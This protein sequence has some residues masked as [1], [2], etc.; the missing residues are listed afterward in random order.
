MAFITPTASSMASKMEKMSDAITY[1]RHFN[2][3]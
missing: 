3:W 1:I 2:W